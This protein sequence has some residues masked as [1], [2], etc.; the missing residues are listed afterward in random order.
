M[1]AA[2]YLATL[3]RIAASATDTASATAPELRDMLISR[4]GRATGLNRA[5]E[6]AEEMLAEPDDVAT[7]R[8]ALDE[9]IAAAI[10][11]SGGRILP[12]PEALR[13]ELAR[14]DEEQRR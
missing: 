5:L 2:D 12:R 1:T 6:L 13:D 10:P 14:F 11:V 9:A 8:R 7:I 3:R 4:A